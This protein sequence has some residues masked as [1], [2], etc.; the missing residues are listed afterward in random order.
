MSPINITEVLVAALATF[1][2]GF[3]I[4]G[5]V[6]GKLWMKLANVHPTG[7]E[8]FSDMWGQMFWNYVA[9]VLTAFVIAGIFWI[10]FSSPVMGEMNAFRGAV[11]AFWLWL[12]FLVTSSAIEVIWMGRSMKLW[13]FEA[14]SS[15]L[16]MLAMGAIIG[17]W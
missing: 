13:L 11:V 12:G 17:G 8:K 2:I 4:H 3:L 1:I 6:A 9:N 5:P 10:A 7:K 16:G 14:F 15:L